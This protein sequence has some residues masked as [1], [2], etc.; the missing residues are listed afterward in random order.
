[1]IVFAAGMVALGVH[2][3][4]ESGMLPGLAGPVWDTGAALSDEST[5]GGLLR[6]VFGYISDPT[7]IEVVAY[8]GY[9][10]IVS[11]LL[12]FRP[13]RQVVAGH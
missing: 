11:W 12:W 6:A 8:L 2:E 10:A 3:L 13:R 7:L 1:M 4:V 9:L 5:V